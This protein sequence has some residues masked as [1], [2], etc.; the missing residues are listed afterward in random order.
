MLS[1]EARDATL[2][3]CRSDGNRGGQGR[4]PRRWLLLTEGA[5]AG[6]R[7]GLGLAVVS[8]GPSA[9]RGSQTSS[10]DF[11]AVFGKAS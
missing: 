11:T 6:L 8:G 7:F 1:V 2:G 10:E 5:R 9:P 3:L 4:M